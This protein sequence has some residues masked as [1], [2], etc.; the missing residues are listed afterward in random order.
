MTDHIHAL[1]EACSEI[2]SE[3]RRLKANHPTPIVVALDGGSGAGK[4][5]LASL[6]EKATDAALIQVD[7]FFTA[8]IPDAEWDARSIEERAR[9]VID[10]RRLRVEALEPLLAGR[11][12]KWHAFDFE[13]GVRADGT[14]RMRTDYVEREPA[15]VI[16][17]DGAYSA[18]PQLAD[19]ADLTVLVEVPVDE[20][21]TRLVAREEE[22]FLDQWHTRWDA[23]EKYYFTRVRPRTSYDLVVTTA[24]PSS[25]RDGRTS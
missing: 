7:D 2:L 12:A 21:H 18:G 14:Y 1:T 16:L 25:P 19:L 20:R 3:I 23:V 5:T 9:A 15:T 17:L 24:Q 10:W 6:I 13:A 22:D 4:S 11:P 8:D